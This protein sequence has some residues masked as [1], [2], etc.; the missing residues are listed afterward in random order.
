M[1][2]EQYDRQYQLCSFRGTILSFEV[3]R[4]SVDFFCRWM[5]Y[6]ERKNFYLPSEV[7]LTVHFCQDKVEGMYQ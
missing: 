2:T 5:L 3:I 7:F 4:T 6:K 1:I